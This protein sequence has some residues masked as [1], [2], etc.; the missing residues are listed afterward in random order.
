MDFFQYKNLRAFAMEPIAEHF[1]TSAAVRAREVVGEIFGS[2]GP[3]QHERDRAIDFWGCI[4]L[5]P[6]QQ[7]AAHLL[8]VISNHWAIAWWRDAD[9]PD[10]S[11]PL[12]ALEPEQ[13]AQLCNETLQA[14]QQYAAFLPERQA[15]AL[16]ALVPETQTAPAPVTDSASNAP[17]MNPPPVATGD[18]AHAFDGLRRW[19]EKAWKDTLGSP[20]KW[21]E[22][23]IALRGERGKRE[24]HWNPVFIGAALVHNAHARANN[25]R[26]RFQTRPQLSAWLE[27]WKTYEAD[28]FDTQ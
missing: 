12:P 11:E 1:S 2:I 19:N 7:A 5:S 3:I 9:T 6:Q 27:A 18:I 28:N 15:V 8:A 10:G 20:P 24:H 16:L 26:A 17:A 4:D 25:I 22:A 23:C 14:A 13:K 21:L